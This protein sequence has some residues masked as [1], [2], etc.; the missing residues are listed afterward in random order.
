MSRLEIAAKSELALVLPSLVLANHLHITGVLPD[1][2][3]WF[4]AGKTLNDGWRVGSQVREFCWHGPQRIHGHPIGLE[5]RLILHTLVVG[6]MLSL[7][8]L[9]IWSALRSNLAGQSLIPQNGPSCPPL[10]APLIEKLTAP[11]FEEGAGE[12]A[13]T[14]D[15]GA[16]YNIDLPC[17]TA[18]VLQDAVCCAV[19]GI[20]NAGLEPLTL[21]KYIKKPELGSRTVLLSPTVL[22]EQVDA[23]SFA[24][25]E[26]TTLMNGGSAIIQEIENGPG[27]QTIKTLKLQ[28]TPRGDVKKTEVT[29]LADTNENLVPV[30]LVLFDYFITKDKLEKSDDLRDCLTDGTEFRQQAFADFNGYNVKP[31]KRSALIQ[32]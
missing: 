22:L 13:A 30:D 27:D 2:I 23:Q 31:L 4:Q 6:N 1:L 3:R 26:E 12:R 14:L 25:G 11:A 9:A 20:D 28:F 29:W 5:S 32:F 7:A 10:L 15:A 24:V 19:T 16:G 18:V 21:P 17:H 8:G